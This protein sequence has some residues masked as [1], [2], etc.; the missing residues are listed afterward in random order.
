MI[1]YIIHFIIML[2]LLLTT[3]AYSAITV[4]ASTRRISGSFSAYDS[5]YELTRT[6]V[7]LGPNNFAIDIVAGYQ[8]SSRCIPSSNDTTLPAGCSDVSVGNL[9]QNTVTYS[10]VANFANQYINAGLFIPA[11]VNLNTVNTLIVC[12]GAAPRASTVVRKCLSATLPAAVVEPPCTIGTT[13]ISISHGSLNANAVSGHIASNYLPI[14]CRT[15]QY[16]RITPA[17]TTNGIVLRSDGSLTTK[18]TVN[19]SNQAN[20]GDLFYV[21]AGEYQLVK[22]SSTLST[23]YGYVTAGAFSGSTVLTINVI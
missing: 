22:I 10:Q 1:R 4:D 5:P 16:I 11:G 12:H 6:K 14:Q 3:A 15:G 19:N 9:T 13:S 17:A 8:S 21:Y 23:P 7:R 18:I 2:Q 20:G